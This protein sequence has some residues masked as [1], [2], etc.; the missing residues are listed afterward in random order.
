MADLTHP[1]VRRQA[2][3]G[4]GAIK[5]SINRLVEMG[6]TTDEAQQ[7]IGE[8]LEVMLTPAAAAPEPEPTPEPEETTSESPAASFVEEIPPEEVEE[9]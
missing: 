1:E 3:V 2:R 8:E 9:E 6:L 5:Q 4:A 7:V